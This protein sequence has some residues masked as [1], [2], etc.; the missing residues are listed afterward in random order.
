M[1]PRLSILIYHRVLPAPDPLLP[2]VPD[3]RQFKRQMALL[4]RCFRVLPLGQAVHRLRQGTLPAR[5]ACITFDDG[6]A[7]NADC[8][9]P[10]LQALDLPAC[11]FIA[12][13]FLDGGRMW[14]DDVIEYVRQAPAGLLD[15]RDIGCG[16]L[17]LHTAADRAGAIDA[18]LNELK[19]LPIGQRQAIASR[20]APAVGPELM[21]S[22]RKLQALHLAGMEIGAHT[23]RHP[24]LARLADDVALDEI[25]RSKRALEHIIQAAVT[26]FA[27]PNGKPGQDYGVQHVRMVAAAGFEAAVSTA[28]GVAGPGS[29]MFQLPRHT[30]WQSDRLRFLFSLTRN[31][32]RTLA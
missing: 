10:V 7:D 22:T 8:A 6:Y 4:K 30:P 15:L 11:F 16:L 2:G 28:H 1:T 18:I 21:L 25:V 13:A 9:L 29:D 27:Y 31:H 26:L 14:N 32:C 3:V 20:L 5:A 12:T 19:Y 23:D 24:I 17:P